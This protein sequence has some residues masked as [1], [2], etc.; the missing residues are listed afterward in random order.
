MH[1]YRIHDPGAGMR[2]QEFSWLSRKVKCCLVGR[3]VTKHV[4]KSSVSRH[5]AG[6]GTMI[7]RFSLHY[8]IRID[9]AVR[10]ECN[11]GMLT[12]P[13]GEVR[14]GPRFLGRNSYLLGK[15]LKFPTVWAETTDI[16]T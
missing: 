10:M 16:K 12:V 15:F 14:S 6:K 11:S 2:N 9:A 8:V 7:M 13:F 4:V 3:E 1:G 5:L